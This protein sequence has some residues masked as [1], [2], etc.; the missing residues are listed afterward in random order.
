MPLT[1][2]YDFS[3]DQL[4]VLDE[5]GRVDAE[6]E[7]DLSREQLLRLFR[8]MLL[9][10][11]ADARMLKLQRQ[12]RIGTFPPGYGAEAI[13]VGVAAAMGEQDWFTGAYRELGARLVLGEPLTNALLYYN[14]WEEGN[15]QPES[16]NQRLLPI[17]VIV[18]SQGLHAVGL[19]YA[20][21]L[22]GERAAAVSFV[23]DG[24]T[25]QGDFH[26]ALNFASTWQLPVVFVVQNNQWAISV[27][28]HKQMRSRSIA[29]RAIGYDMPGLQ[30]DGNDVLA[31]YRAAR[32]AL[33]RAYA[34][35]GPSL[36]EAVTYR[37][38]MHTTADDP[39]K[40]RDPAEVEPWE[41]KEPLLRFRAYLEGKGY[42]DGE[43]QAALE[44]EIKQEVQAAVEAFE[45]QAAFPPE[46]PFDH[47]YGTRDPQLE[48]QK[49]EFLAELERGEG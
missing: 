39:K 32:E 34:G 22:R 31:V 48:A 9:T 42:W 37:L 7:P 6:L 25:S 44:A 10:R 12:G 26:E 38:S 43:Q 27:P 24:G 15:V 2:L 23:G 16:G 21:K 46:R 33:T 17:S 5:Q 14:G 30:V 20:S 13:S 18:G 28:R 3:V 41:A 35:E 45:A 1:K 47:V 40:Y 49:Q 36:I 19:A 4:Q 11:E 8:Y 29:Q